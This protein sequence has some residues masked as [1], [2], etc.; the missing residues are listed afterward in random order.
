M[1][2]S[3]VVTDKGDYLLFIT[4]GSVHSAEDFWEWS[5]S[6][7]TKAQEFGKTKLLFDNRTFLLD[8]TQYDVL[9]VVDRWVEMDAPSL[10]LKFAVISSRKSP[11]I[12]RFIE[13][14]FTNRSAAYKR[15]SH[16]TEALGWLLP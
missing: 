1:S 10:G 2:Y 3:L 9:T 5:M 4:D 8:I 13:T 12:S 15:F 14:S 7:V 11:E 16:Q 6:I